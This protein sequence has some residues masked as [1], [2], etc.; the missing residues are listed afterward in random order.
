MP[1]FA[2]KLLCKVYYTIGLQYVGHLRLLRAIG[3]GEKLP[4][5][6]FNRSSFRF[7]KSLRI[8]RQEVTN[9]ADSHFIT[10]CQ[11][12]WPVG[13]ICQGWHGYTNGYSESTMTWI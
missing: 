5:L 12:S 8:L 9:S 4:H 6:G 7:F 3:D 13:P 1:C 11:L 2:L 10:F